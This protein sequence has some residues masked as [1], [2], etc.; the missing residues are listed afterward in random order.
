MLTVK[1]VAK[2]L[3]VSTATVYKLCE[4]GEL[5]HVR[6]LN[7]LRVAPA[8]LSDFIGGSSLS[9]D[10]LLGG[11]MARRSR[12]STARRRAARCMFIT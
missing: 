9:S 12:R 2:R 8:D 11:L 6:I 4:K 5:A 1:Q 3:Q 10:S 7:S